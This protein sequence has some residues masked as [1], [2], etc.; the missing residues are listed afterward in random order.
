MSDSTARPVLTMLTGLLLGILLGVAVGW[1]TLVLGG[2][3]DDSGRM[4]LV[5][6]A[7]VFALVSI[8]WGRGR[9]GWLWGLASATALGGLM[10]AHFVTRIGH[11]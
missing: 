2:R 5:L 3:T 7:A 4:G 6:G 8:G 9:R 1:V 10:L 11:P